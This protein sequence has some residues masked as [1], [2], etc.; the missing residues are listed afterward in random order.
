MPNA[1]VNL[2]AGAP[3]RSFASFLTLG[4]LHIAT[5]WDHLLFLFAL[6]LGGGRLG[7]LVK[8]VTAFTVAHSVTL[9]AAA[10]D[11]VTLP[12][13]LVESAIALS[14]VYVAVENMVLGER[15]V[16]K[17]WLVALLFGSIHGFGFSSVLKDIGLPADGL[18]WALF[19]FNLGAEA[20]QLVI[21]ACAVPLLWMLQRVSWR[22]RAVQGVSATTAL[23]GSAVFVHRAFL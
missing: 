3:G 18:A 8:I 20:G 9:I 10:L 14:I 16:S 4:I 1:T 23:A 21:V 15:G 17:R 13:R 11:V 7:Q 22:R 5:G 19:A 6:L 2:S 12:E